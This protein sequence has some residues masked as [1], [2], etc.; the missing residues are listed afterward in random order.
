MN[1]TIY[2]LRALF[3]VVLLTG[4]SS[5]VIAQFSGGSGT[6]S[7]PYLI[8]TLTDLSTLSTNSTYWSA[9]F[10]QTADIDAS[11]TSGWDSG[12]GFSP[13]GNVGTNFSGHYNGSGHTI[14]GLFINRSSDSYIGLFGY[15]SGAVI[16]S[17]GVVNENITGQ[18]EVGGLVG[19][20]D[21][22]STI[23]NSYSTGSVSGSSYVGG[24]VGLNGSSSAISNSYSSG[25]VSGSSYVGGLVG[26]NYSSSSIISNSY[27]TGSVSGSSN[28]GGLVG[29]N[30]STVTN[31]FWDTET[32]GQTTSAG[33]AGKTTAQMKTAATYTDAGWDFMDETANGTNDYWGINETGAQNNGYPFLAWQGYSNLIKPTVTTGAVTNYTG[34]TATGNGTINTLGTANLTAYGVCWNTTG[35][36]TITDSKT[37]KGAASATGAFTTAMTGLTSNTTYYVR[38]YVTNAT[39]TS[40]GAVVSFTTYNGSG[41]SSDPYLISTLDNL[42]NLSASPLLWDKYF[43]QTA[44]IDASATSGWDSGK[45]FSPIGNST[46]KFTGNYNGGGHTITGLFI[47]RGS[48]NYIGLFG[49]TS[50]AVI[51]SVGVVNENITGQDEVGGLVG[52]N[53]SSTISN[54]YSTG[55][56]SGSGYVGGLVGYSSSSSTISNSYSTASAS[57]VYYVGGLVGNNYS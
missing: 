44:D 57:G 25:S 19:L 28:V 31:S 15:T 24:L 47:N 53:Y 42:K 29:L 46:T 55:S 52:I 10:K 3:V 32:S 5:S 41:N 14:T 23:S 6:S 35:T 13:I 34:N 36:P 21:G 12:K 48:T 22:S 1:K 30:S 51:D 20:N 27:S 26:Y 7:D 39:G 8:S 54:S 18:N 17:V 9:Y 4:F 33:G 2:L 37:D 16:D 38:A 11:A 45:G 40:Y 56:V 49:Y 50:G 43:K